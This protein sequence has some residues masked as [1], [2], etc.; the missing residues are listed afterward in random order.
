MELPI[1]EDW[2]FDNKI[3][4]PLATQSFQFDVA[5]LFNWHLKPKSEILW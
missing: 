4:K 2:H 5:H 1:T 3:R